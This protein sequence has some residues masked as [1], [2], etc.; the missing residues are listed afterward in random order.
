MSRIS[1]LGA[2]RR[3]NDLAVRVNVPE[4]WNVLIPCL[5]A[6]RALILSDT[7]FVFCRVFDHFSAVPAMSLCGNKLRFTSRAELRLSTSCGRSGVMSEFRK[8]CVCRV[9][10]SRTCVVC[11]PSD[12]SAC[13]RFRIVVQNVVPQCGNKDFFTLRADLR[14]DARCRRPR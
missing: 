14:I 3:S 6:Y 12:I 11:I 8:F 9:I 7:H 13:C 4:F 1:G 10:A 5:M 2:S